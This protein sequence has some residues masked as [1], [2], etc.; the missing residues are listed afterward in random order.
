MAPP[1][2]IYL[3]STSPEYPNTAEGQE[4]DLKFNLIKMIGLYR[5][6]E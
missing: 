6:Y 5:G 1:E 4:D 3:P 2:F